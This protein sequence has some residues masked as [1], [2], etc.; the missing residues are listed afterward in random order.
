MQAPDDDWPGRMAMTNRAA[1]SLFAST[2][3]VAA[4]TVGAMLVGGWGAGILDN[5]V[6]W[7]F[8]AGAILGAIGI[9]LLGLAALPPG[10][11]PAL[12]LSRANGLVRAGLALFLV[13]PVLCVVAVFTD[14]WI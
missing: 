8:W 10:R 7:V 14:Y 3:V 2:S 4:I 1:T 12:S 13:A 9:G 6:E 11:D 5:R